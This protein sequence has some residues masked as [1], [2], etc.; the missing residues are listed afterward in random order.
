MVDHVDQMT[1]I[2]DDQRKTITQ[3]QA[4]L[5]QNR[6]TVTCLLSSGIRSKCKLK[7]QIVALTDALRDK[8]KA[9]MDW[10]RKYEDLMVKLDAIDELLLIR[11]AINESVNALGTQAVE[12]TRR[13]E[14]AA[15]QAKRLERRWK[16]MGVRLGEK[17]QK[18]DAQPA[19]ESECADADAD[20]SPQCRRTISS[21]IRNWEAFYKGTGAPQLRKC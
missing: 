8:D 2:C 13:V 6:K 14:G 1:K 20:E 9:A 10:K 7:E 15:K 4:D 12:W 17:G 18:E 19:G 16:E 21:R 5:D 11:D 3:L